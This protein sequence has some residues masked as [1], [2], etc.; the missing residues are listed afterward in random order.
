MTQSDNTMY[1]E[2]NHYLFNCDELVWKQLTN[3]IV[4]VYLRHPKASGICWDLGD[5]IRDDNLGH[6][7]RIDCWHH[8]CFVNVCCAINQLSQS[9]PPDLNSFY[10]KK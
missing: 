9:N 2:M 7:R 3:T 6:D 10:L 8:R 4:F 5:H 1:V